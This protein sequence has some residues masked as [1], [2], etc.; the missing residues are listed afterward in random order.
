MEAP[1]SPDAPTLPHMPPPSARAAPHS[2]ANFRKEAGH[3]RGVMWRGILRHTRFPG[4]SVG[5]RRCDGGAV[6]GAAADG[7][8]DPARARERIPAGQGTFRALSP[9]LYRRSGHRGPGRRG[10]DGAVE[11]GV[12]EGAVGRCG[13]WTC[14]VPVTLR[15]G[16]RAS[17]RVGTA[18]SALPTALGPGAR[19]PGPPIDPRAQVRGGPGMGYVRGRGVE[20]HP[21]EA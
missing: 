19:A 1:S 14:G 15:Y 2:T 8:S 18:V 5:T 20:G 4:G 13:A 17:S 9:C 7:A 10:R 11:W 3:G 12:V 6:G 21:V 16:R